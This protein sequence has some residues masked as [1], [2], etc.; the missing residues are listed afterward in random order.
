MATFTAEAN[1]IRY[2]QAQWIG[3]IFPVAP[4]SFFG[5]LISLPI[6]NYTDLSVFEAFHAFISVIYTPVRFVHLFNY[7]LYVNWS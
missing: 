4:P 1:T 2:T 7:F 6:H 5:D 3:F